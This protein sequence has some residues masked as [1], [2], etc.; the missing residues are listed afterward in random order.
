MITKQQLWL[1]MFANAIIN[2]DQR[3]A[4]RYANNAVRALERKFDN[5]IEHESHQ[6][7]LR[8]QFKTGAIQRQVWS[9]VLTNAIINND[10]RTAM[11][12]ANYAVTA[13][14]CNFDTETMEKKRIER[15]SKQDQFNDLL[16]ID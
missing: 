8:D 9:T 13:F 10:A 4:N 16:E 14:V 3:T 7:E 15:E 6:A 11:E 12:Y 5:P 1:T 2:N